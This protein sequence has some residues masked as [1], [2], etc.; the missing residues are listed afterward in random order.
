MKFD[1][2]QAKWEAVGTVAEVKQGEARKM[3]LDAMRETTRQMVSIF[4]D[5]WYG[6]LQWNN[7][8][9]QHELNQYVIQMHEEFGIGLIST[10]DSHYPNPEAWKNRE[11]YKNHSN[12][13]PQTLAGPYFKG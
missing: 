12:R 5:R 2:E 1:R 11:L 10:A 6:E 3:V 7:I 8:S 13:P 9:E 4:G